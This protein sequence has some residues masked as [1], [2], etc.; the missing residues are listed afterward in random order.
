MP[1]TFLS[2]S[3]RV[4]E[5]FDVADVDHQGTDEHAVLA[6]SEM[7]RMLVSNL[8]MTVGDL[9]GDAEPVFADDFYAGEEVVSTF[10]FQATDTIRSLFSRFSLLTL[11]QFFR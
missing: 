6:C 10:L 11:R 3:I 5:F 7:V 4:S 9:V 8:E 2:F 1:C